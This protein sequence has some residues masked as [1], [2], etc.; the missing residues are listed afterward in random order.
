MSMAHIRKTYG[1][2]AKRG[3]RVVPKV[4]AAKGWPG[5]IRS[6]NMSDRLIVT[7]ER[8]RSGGDYWGS[9]HPNDLDYVDGAK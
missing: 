7:G 8:T 6:S 3:M 9:Y 4:G 2:P 1:V 5:Y